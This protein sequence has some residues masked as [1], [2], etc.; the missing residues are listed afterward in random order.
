MDLETKTRNSDE[1]FAGVKGTREDVA[2]VLNTLYAKLANAQE[3]WEDSASDSTW[4][5]YYSG[6]VHGLQAAIDAVKQLG[7]R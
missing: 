1:Y 7:V 3:A 5:H 6:R 4:V 2:D